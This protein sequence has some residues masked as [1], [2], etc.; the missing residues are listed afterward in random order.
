MSYWRIQLALHSPISTPMLSG[1]LFGHLCWAYRDLHTEQALNL[2]I[3]SLHHSPFL[4]SDAFPVNTLPKPILPPEGFG[5]N[6]D[7]IKAFKKI[8]HLPLGDF[9]STRHQMSTRTL[10]DQLNNT[11][12]EA[13]FDNTCRIAHNRINR[14]TGTTPQSGGLYFTEEHWPQSAISNADSKDGFRPNLDVYASSSLNKDEIQMLFQHIGSVGFGKD[15]SLGR[16]RFTVSVSSP[17]SGLFDTHGS[18]CLS[19]SHGSL[20][21]NMAN[22]RYAVRTHYGKLGA[23][24][25]N[26]RSPFKYPLTLLQPGSTFTPVGD[27]PHGS[28]LT[29]LHPDPDLNGIVHNAW[30]LTVNYSERHND[31]NS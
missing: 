13:Y 7:N 14:V 21:P 18:R 10:A 24:L 11:K 2:W 17:P 30:H 9:L 29:D 4:I 20:T 5:E 12:R 25:A 3:E 26:H 19:L 1:T 16:G 6:R 8:R 23:V 27:G 28:L 31:G 22:A 15:A